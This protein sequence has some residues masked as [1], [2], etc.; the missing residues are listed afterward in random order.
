M[1]TAAT[2]REL[3]AY[4]P[5]TGL[6]RYRRNTCRHVIGDPAGAVIRSGYVYISFGNR[7]DGARGRRYGAHRLAW[8]YMTGEW[9]QAEIDHVNGSRPDNRWSNLRTA[10]RE[11]NMQNQRC[12][13]D[14]AGEGMKGAYFQKGSWVAVIQGQRRKVYLGS[15][16]TA[17]EAHAAYVGASVI[18]HGE[19]A[20]SH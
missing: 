8:L 6:F 17:A 18:L 1:L 5:E 9:P 14:K 19:F 3:F 11:Q 7:A 10:T 4:E 20:R 12:H 16:A 13:R 2:L 15:F